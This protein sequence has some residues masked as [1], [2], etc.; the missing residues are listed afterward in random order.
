M[1]R[2]IPFMLINM[3]AMYFATSVGR[4]T[5]EGGRAVWNTSHWT[6]IRSTP[7]HE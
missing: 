6:F 2:K 4:L 1:I 5:G 3:K 7:G